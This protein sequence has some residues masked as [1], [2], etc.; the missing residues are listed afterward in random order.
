DRLIERGLG[1]YFIH[2][3]GHGVGLEVHEPPW[4]GPG[5]NDKLM[6]DDVV[7]IEPGVYIPNRYGVRIEDTI[8]ISHGVEILTKFPKE[9]II[10]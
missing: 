3:T 9:L 8:H 5:S 1:E 6:K 10:L 7:T 4:L 2:S